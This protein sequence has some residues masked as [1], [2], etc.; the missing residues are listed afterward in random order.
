M[1]HRGK[2]RAFKRS[3]P[4]KNNTEADLSRLEYYLHDGI[5]AIIA[6]C[7]AIDHHIPIPTHIVIRPEDDENDDNNN[8]NNEEDN[9]NSCSAKK[10]GRTNIPSPETSPSLPVM[11]TLGVK[12]TLGLKT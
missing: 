10:R 11:H 6:P 1:R 4:L 12:N 9:E 7:Q 8:N 5:L 3:F 2:W